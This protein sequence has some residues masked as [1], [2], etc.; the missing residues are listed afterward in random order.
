MIAEGEGSLMIVGK[1]AQ[2]LKWLV[3]QKSMYGRS[4]DEFFTDLKFLAF[5]FVLAAGYA[6]NERREFAALIRKFQVFLK[7]FF[8][9]IV[10][11]NIILRTLQRYLETMQQ[12]AIVRKNSNDCVGC[13]I[14]QT[15]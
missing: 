3:V 7:V 13:I 4:V 2:D 15:F 8:A 11:N 10:I 1:F 12:G 5:Q 14:L 9:G 6:T